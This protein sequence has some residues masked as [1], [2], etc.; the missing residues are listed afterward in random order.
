MVH[1]LVKYTPELAFVAPDSAGED[2]DYAKFFRDCMFDWVME[3][4]LDA[5]RGNIIVE[6]S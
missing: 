5:I 2:F 4:E 1:K 6:D 3:T